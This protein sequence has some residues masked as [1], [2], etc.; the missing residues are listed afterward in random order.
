MMSIL[1]LKMPLIAAFFCALVLLACTPSPQH[2]I[3]LCSAPSIPI[4]KVQGD[5]FESP[6]V[7][8]FVTVQ[9]I[10]T[11][12]RSGDGLYLQQAEAES[13]P[14]LHSSSA[15][16]IQSALIPDEIKEGDLIA[17][18]G[19]VVELGEGRDTQT[20]LTGIT[21]PERCASSQP[22]PLTIIKMP[23]DN[24]ERES[25]EGMRVQV[26][27]PL[28]ATDVYQ[29]GRGNVT[30]SGNGLQYVATEVMQPGPN[31]VEYR[32]RNRAYALSVHIPE[33]MRLPGLIASGTPVG[34]LIGVMGHD[35]QGKRVILQSPPNFNET[36]FPVP[37][38]AAPD[39]LRVV[40]IN[41]HNYFNGDGIGGGFPT[42]RGAETIAEFQHQR[43]RTGAAIKVLDPHVVAVMEL[44]NDGFGK[45][46]AAQD[47][48]Q[49]ANDFTGQKWQVTR[50]VNDDTGPDVIAV[51]ILYRLDKLQ[52]I[53]PSKTLKGE[54]FNAS[55]QPQ[56][57]L[58]QRLD[59]NKKLLVVI[60]HLKS[61][62][63]CPETGENANQNDGQGC[64]NPIRR[65]SAQKMSAWA[66]S[67]AAASGTDNILILGDMNAYRKEDPINAIRQSGFIELTERENQAANYSFAYYGQHG[68][69]DYAFGTKALLNKVHRAYIWQVNSTLP[70]NMELPKPWLRFSD[71]DAVVVDLF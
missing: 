14:D 38:T 31:A 51:G 66:K 61:K 54:E 2:S 39:T 46:S 4:S 3:N 1:N 26:D 32:R 41:L 7:G 48:I 13:D 40:G 33:D 67:V 55:R 19:N 68:T 47:L 21:S 30:L 63:S 9:G 64:W 22:L 50:P 57:Q 59:N 23:M 53:G 62:G 37:D 8:Q 6:L 70:G 18:S 20:S 12:I 49:L 36:V 24:A 43:A 60:N 35:K 34:Q 45:N 52:A 5:G 44:E 11:L 28:V 71:H 29:F 56:A 10:V 58:F 25:L 27:G 16:F 42:P 15:I 69:L 65:S 17:L